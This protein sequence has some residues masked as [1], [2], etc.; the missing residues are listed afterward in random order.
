VRGPGRGRRAVLRDVGPVDGVVYRTTTSWP[1]SGPARA[2]VIAERLISTLA[3][4]HAVVPAE[5]GLAEFGRPQGFLARQ[6]RRWKEAARRVALAA[7]WPAST[8]CTRCSRPIPRRLAARH[9]A[10]RL[11]AGQRACRGRRQD[12]GGGGLGDGHAWRPADR[13]RACS[14]VYQRMDRLGEG[15]MPATRPAY[16]SVPEVLDLYDRSQRAGT[17]PTLAST[18]P[19]RRSKRCGDPRGHPFQVR[20]RPDGRARGSRRSAPWSSPW[21]LPDWPRCGEEES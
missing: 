12:R 8:S 19:S 7:R 6:V 10:R 3:Q 1:R 21:S 2:R 16:P 17:F 18:S 11:P 5:V 14:S 13:R 9:R 15:P 4:L 20:P